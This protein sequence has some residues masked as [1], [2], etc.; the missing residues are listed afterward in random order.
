MSHHPHSFSCP[1]G[2]CVLF[3]HLVSVLYLSFLIVVSF[4]C[5]NAY[6]EVFV[7]AVVAAI[8]ELAI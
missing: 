2:T 6:L 1:S 3:L 5:L 4:Y 8:L 7:V